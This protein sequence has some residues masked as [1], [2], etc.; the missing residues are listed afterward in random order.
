MLALTASSYFI[1]EG[2]YDKQRTGQVCETWQCKFY[3]GGI[4]L[5]SSRNT[6]SKL[7]LI[8]PERIMIITPNYRFL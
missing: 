8:Q 1:I 6:E 2:L 4:T 7:L 3:F 5:T